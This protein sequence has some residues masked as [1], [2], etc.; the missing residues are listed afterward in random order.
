[1]VTHRSVLTAAAIRRR[2]PPHTLGFSRRGVRVA[3]RTLEQV[4][5][6][7]ALRSGAVHGQGP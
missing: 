4:A 7:G 6:D 3:W 2:H 5:V 1:M